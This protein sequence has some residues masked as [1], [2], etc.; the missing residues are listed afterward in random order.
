VRMICPA[1]SDGSATRDEVTTAEIAQGQ[2]L[3]GLE[4]GLDTKSDVIA[5]VDQVDAAVRQVDLHPD[6]G[7]AT[8][9]GRHRA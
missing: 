1:N 6:E 3:V 2:R 7:I 5:L 8:E 4:V 9:K